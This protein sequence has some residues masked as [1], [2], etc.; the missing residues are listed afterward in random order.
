MACALE[1]NSWI[2]PELSSTLGLP[3]ERVGG[4]VWG[5]S[6]ALV[7]ITQPFMESLDCALE[8]VSS[9]ASLVLF[10]D[11]IVGRKDVTVLT[12]TV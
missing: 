8:G 9:G 7:Q 3:R 12:I 5:C 6:T 1:L 11:F 10:G 4:Q 2:W